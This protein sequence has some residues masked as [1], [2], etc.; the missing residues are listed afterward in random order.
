[1]TLAAVGVQSALLDL[2]SFPLGDMLA[3]VAATYAI[4]AWAERPWNLAGMLLIAAG[5]GAHAAIFYPGGVVAAL[6]GGVALPWSVGRVVRGNR[7]LTRAGRRR[8]A[9]IERSRALEARA[10]VIR[11]RVRVARELHDAVAHS[12]SV[13]AIQAGGAE[14]LVERDPERASECAALIASVA[15]EALAELARLTG[16]P[17]AGD[18]GADAAPTCRASTSSPCA[19]APPGWP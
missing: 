17:A 3:M 18:G 7:E 19:R 1:M 6:L 15:E 9:E 5:A 10:A 12:I 2:D 13:I 8:N 4:G 16:L 14:G 11:E